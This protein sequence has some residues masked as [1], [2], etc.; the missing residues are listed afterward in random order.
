MNNFLIKNNVIFSDESLILLNNYVEKNRFSSVFVLVDSNTEKHCLNYFIQ[1]VNFSFLTIKIEPGET[2]KNIYTCLKIWEKLSG[3][4]ADRK[5]LLLNLGGGVVTDT[6]GFVA[7]CYRRGISFVHIPTT[8]LAMVD[9][10]IGGKNGVDLNN[11]KNQI[12]VIK[13]PEK[14]VIDKNFLKTLPEIEV[15]SGY[16]EILKHG[17]ID[18]KKSGYFYKCL[19]SNNFKIEN[20][21]ELIEDSVKIKLN[22]VAEDL[23]ESGLRKILNFG[24]TLGHAIE[25]YRMTFEEKYQLLHG[26]AIAIGL[27]LE[28]YISHKLYSFPKKDLDLLKT[29]IKKNYQSQKF[30]IEDQNNI[31]NLMK[32]DKKNEGK[33]VNFVLLEDIGVPHLDCEV[34]ENFIFEAFKYYQS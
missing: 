8:L 19:S 16:A 27:V 30:T 10:A 15:T 9:A 6:G 18:I 33:K 7:S 28:T 1:K 17:M 3:Y 29:F 5:S 21:V 23:N 2:N 12:G 34:K 22:T 13:L 26:E 14:I 31:I 20:I 25:S 32:Y 24:H 11:L 4:E